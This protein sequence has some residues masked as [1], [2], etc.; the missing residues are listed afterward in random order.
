MATEGGGL[1]GVGVCKQG[2]RGFQRAVEPRI[3]N[4]YACT[5]FVWKRLGLCVTKERCSGNCTLRTSESIPSYLVTLIIGL[6][7]W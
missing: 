1:R 6:H 4:M 2:V 5:R 7:L 3:E